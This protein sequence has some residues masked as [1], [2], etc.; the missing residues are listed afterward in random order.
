M[1]PATAAEGLARSINPPTMSEASVCNYPALG[2]V[3][4]ELYVSKGDVRRHSGDQGR[5]LPD[6]KHDVEQAGYRE[7]PGPYQTTWVGSK[8]GEPDDRIQATRVFPCRLHL[9]LPY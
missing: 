6:P 5:G 4:A 9:S 8:K 1:L 3:D 7:N 2:D